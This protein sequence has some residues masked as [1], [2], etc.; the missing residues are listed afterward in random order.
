MT[1]TQATECGWTAPY[2]D[3]LVGVGHIRCNRPADTDVSLAPL[4][5]EDSWRLCA[6]HARVFASRMK[7]S[8]S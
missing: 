5:A 1:R 2:S 3:A 8:L 7:G 4:G 6:E